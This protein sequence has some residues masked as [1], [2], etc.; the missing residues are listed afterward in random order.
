MSGGHGHR[1]TADGGAVVLDVGG[2]VGALVLLAPETSRGLEIEISRLHEPSAPRQHVAVHPRFLG[3]RVVHA[4]VYADLVEGDYVLW[5]PDGEAVL[6][7]SVTG[8][9]V[10]E[11]VWPR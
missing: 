2:E 7:V 5:S 4:A 3:D 8:G 10:H 1:H 6:S 11:V 9:A